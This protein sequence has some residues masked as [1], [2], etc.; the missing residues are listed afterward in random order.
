M[1]VFTP[2]YNPNRWLPVVPTETRNGDRGLPDVSPAELA[3]MKRENAAIE[4]EAQELR[5]QLERS[6]KGVRGTAVRGQTRHASGSH[7]GRY[8]G[9]GA[10]PPEKRTEV[11][12]YLAAKF[13][14]T[15]TIKPE[16]I[17]AAFLP[18]EKARSQS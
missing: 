5:R 11:Q 4:I 10:N 18:G 15:L 6:A 17:I 14:A 12:K 3:V 7:P 1:A 8:R 2:A 9:R 16:E 13:A